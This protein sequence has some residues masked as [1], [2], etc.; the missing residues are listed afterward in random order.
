MDSAAITL[1]NEQVL[2][3]RAAA[4]PGAFAAIYDHYFPRIYNYTRYRVQ[5][6]DVAADLT[7]QIFERALSAIQ[8]Y[9]P[10]RG[11]FAAWLFAIARNTLRDHLRAQKRRHW[12][13]LDILTDRAS[14]DPPL[15]QTVI[16]DEERDDLMDAITRLNEREK[17]FIALKF[18]A[19]LTNRRIAELTGMDERHV[20]MI[21]WRAMQRLRVELT[22]KE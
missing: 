8:T 18:G 21:V 22:Q 20:S 2:V 17:D 1:E 15:E 5:C 19:R 4:E 12:L 16:R 11:P 9:H 10:E 13:S 3:S 6:P 14:A 7:A